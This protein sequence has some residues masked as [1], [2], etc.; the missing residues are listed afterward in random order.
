ME[1][2]CELLSS[3]EDMVPD[4]DVSSFMLSMR[5]VMIALKRGWLV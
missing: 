1:I 4:E 3:R 2:V 5:K